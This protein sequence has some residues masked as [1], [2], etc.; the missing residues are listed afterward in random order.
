MISKKTMAMFLLTEKVDKAFTYPTL[1]PKCIMDIIADYC[2]Y[3]CKSRSDY[4]QMI[5]FLFVN[6][7]YTKEV[8][9]SF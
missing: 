9:L 3:G 8:L 5:R 7:G 4:E 1:V 2:T 6:D